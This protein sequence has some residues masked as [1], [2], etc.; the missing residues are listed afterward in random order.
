MTNVCVCVC[1]E[2]TGYYLR[3]VHV[4]FQS[5][6]NLLQQEGAPYANAEEADRMQV[7]VFCRI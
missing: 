6:I 2:S 5:L 3:W 7:K 1:A 4:C